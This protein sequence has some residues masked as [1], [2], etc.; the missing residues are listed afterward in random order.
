MR[1]LFESL[2][3]RVCLSAGPGGEPPPLPEPSLPAEPTQVLVFSASNSTDDVG[4]ATPVH[5]QPEPNLTDRLPS[6][7]AT[8]VVEIPTL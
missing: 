8:R 6:I 5:G 4:A 7:R 1:V 3:C 2:D